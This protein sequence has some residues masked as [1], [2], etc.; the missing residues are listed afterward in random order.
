MLRKSYFLFLGVVVSASAFGSDTVNSRR[1]RDAFIVEARAAV[2]RDLLDPASAQFRDLYV[3]Q[4]GDARALCG[5]INAKNSYGAY[6]GFRPFYATKING[7]ISGEILKSP[8]EEDA[9]FKTI[10]TGFCIRAK[11]AS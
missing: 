8:E 1:S 9:V 11:K 2:S 5:E 10:Y 7:R 4:T 3:T 6:T